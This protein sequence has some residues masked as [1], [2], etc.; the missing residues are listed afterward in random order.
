MKKGLHCGTKIMR[1]D[2]NFYEEKMKIKLAAQTLRKSTSDALKYFQ[3]K[4]L[5]DFKNAGHS[6][7]FCKNFNDIFD[8][9]NVRTNIGCKTETLQSIKLVNIDAWERKVNE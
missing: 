5:N 1:R 4:Q 7:T 3:K 8:F 9:L 2:T 6:S